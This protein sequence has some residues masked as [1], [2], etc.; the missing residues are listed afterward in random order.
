MANLASYPRPINQAATTL[1]SPT[2]TPCAKATRLA[3]ADALG[4][5]GCPTPHA[6]RQSYSTGQR[7]AQPTHAHA[8][9]QSYS[10][11]QRLA[12]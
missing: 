4:Q 3:N 6:L 11:G 5:S 8:L 9:R 10:T 12:Q 2:P 1:I 7:L